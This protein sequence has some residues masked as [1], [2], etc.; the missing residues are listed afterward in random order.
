MSQQFKLT[1]IEWN[2]LQR[3]F[4]RSKHSTLDGLNGTQR[5]DKLKAYWKC[6]KKLD[7]LEQQTQYNRI[8]REYKHTPILNQRTSHRR[9]R[10]RIVVPSIA[11][12]TEANPPPHKRQRLGLKHQKHKAPALERLYKRLQE[13]QNELKD[14]ELL[15]CSTNQS[16]HQ[17]VK[18]KN[19][20]KEIL[21]EIE[22]IKNQIVFRKQNNESVKRCKAR[23]KLN[24][25]I[26]PLEP[27][28]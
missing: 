28:V 2:E 13:K 5:M 12:I 14:A 6:M 9:G 3:I 22:K 10:K 19:K 15:L 8:V 23:K 11:H 21:S 20:Q 18:R 27:L 16:I 17:I 1:T 4:K 26:P 24:K 7:V 25:K